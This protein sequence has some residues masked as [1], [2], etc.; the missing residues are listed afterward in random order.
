MA[1]A[2]VMHNEELS[3][4]HFTTSAIHIIEQLWPRAADRSM[5]DVTRQTVSMLALWSVLRWERKVG[6]VALERMGVE[7]D[8]LARDV[9]RALDAAC[10]EIRRQHG[11]PHWE[12]LPSGQRGIV[13]DFRAPLAALLDAAEHEA[14]GLGHNWVGSEHLLLATIRVADPCLREVLDRHRV[15]YDAVRQ[16]VLDILHS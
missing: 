1:E 16:T 3:A 9:D 15:A 6:L 10:A 7:L 8:A 12:T 14:L 11:T 5:F 13:V 4:R 2:S